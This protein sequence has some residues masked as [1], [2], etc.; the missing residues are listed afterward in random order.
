MDFPL[1]AGEQFL[2]VTARIKTDIWP[3]GRQLRPGLLG[4]TPIELQIDWS[5]FIG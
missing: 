1:A 4:I 3:A 5:V 2:A